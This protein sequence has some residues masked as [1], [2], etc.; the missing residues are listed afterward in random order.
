MKKLLTIILLLSVC[1]IYVFGAGDKEK[2]ESAVPGTELRTTLRVAIPEHWRIIEPLQ[3]GEKEKVVPRRMWFYESVM[4]FKEKFPGIKLQFE[5]VPWDQITMSFINKSLAG[6]PPDIQTLAN[7]SQYVFARAG[8]VHPL[9]EF[10][11]PWDDFGTNIFENNMKVDGK[12]YMIP[13]YIFSH[14]LHYNK[15]MY[16]DAGISSPPITMDELIADSKK[17][18]IDKNGDGNPDIWGFGIPASTVHPAFV[19]QNWD[20]LVW[21]NGGKVAENG[22]A[23]FDTPAGRNATQ[24]YVDLVYKHKVAPKAITAWDKE[25][26]STWYRAERLAMTFRGPEE[27]PPSIKALGDKARIARIPLYKKGDAYKSWMELFGW[28]MSKKAGED[29]VKKKAAWEFLK[30]LV[31][32]EAFV[33]MAKHQHGLPSRKSVADNPIYKSDPVF[34][35]QSKYTVEAGQADPQIEGWEPW[36]DIVART[37]QAAVLRL[38]GVDELMKDAQRDYNKAVK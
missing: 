7:G 25:Y 4:M 28:V 8:Y 34:E 6:D 24:F 32:E 36:R 33:S 1:I 15:G 14:V 2:T 35:F 3:T 30:A 10:E 37:V 18:T 17:L 38:K 9:D 22:K 21:L 31:T 11:F 13:A 5:A 27:H 29:P 20:T 26:M 16:D 19:Y 12:I 23:L